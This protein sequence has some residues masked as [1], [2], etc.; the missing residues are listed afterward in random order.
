[1][2]LN[3]YNVEKISRVLK[4]EIFGEAGCENIMRMFQTNPS[5]S[6][7]G[8]L[9]SEGINAFLTIKQDCNKILMWEILE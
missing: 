5:L 1:M 4:V 8:S 3:D 7:E 2:G 6:C 9:T